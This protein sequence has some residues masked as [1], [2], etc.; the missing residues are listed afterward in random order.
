L[1]AKYKK[2]CYNIKKQEKYGR[3]AID[4]IL[5]NGKN[6]IIYW[7]NFEKIEKISR[8]GRRPN[9]KIPL[10]GIAPRAGLIILFSWPRE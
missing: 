7:K 10:N 2:I 4:F 5:F 6:F 8:Q 1:V 3:Q 9:K